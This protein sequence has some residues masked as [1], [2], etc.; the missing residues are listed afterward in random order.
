L[1]AVSSLLDTFLISAERA[2]ERFNN[3]NPEP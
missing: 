1:D 2:I 3:Q